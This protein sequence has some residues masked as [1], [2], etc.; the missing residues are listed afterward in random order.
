[1][2]YSAGSCNQRKWGRKQWGLDVEKSR[3]EQAEAKVAVLE[4]SQTGKKEGA[5]KEV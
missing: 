1:M 2:R 3:C 5:F 4:I